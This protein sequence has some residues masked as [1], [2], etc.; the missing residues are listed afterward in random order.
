MSHQITILP[1]GKTFLA[2]DDET[3][4]D[5]ALRQGVGLPYGCRDGACGACKGSVLEGQVE[6]GP[7]KPHALSAAERAAGKALFCCASARSDLAIECRQV[8]DAAE[9]PART[10]PTRVQKLTR[11]ADDVAIIELKLPDKE[12]LP[13]R[14]GQYVDI[15]LRDGRR[16]SFSLANAPHDDLRLELHVRHIP[17]GAFTDHVFSTMKERDILR[18]NGPHGSFYLRQDSAKP[19]LLVAGGTGFAP[20]KA[21]VE[22]ARHAG[23]ERPMTL[24]WGARDRAGLYLHDLALGWSDLAY[25]PVLSAPA[26]DDHWRGRVGLVHEAVMADLPDLSGYQV[27]CCGAPAMVDAAR[28]DFTQRCALPEEAFFAD[29]FSYAVDSACTT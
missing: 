19:I 26:A 18:I 23:N 16:R 29:A 22:H 2:N 20:I 27:Y 3:L 24:Y 28:R 10:L 12:R 14:P 21:I 13:F 17:G 4:L 25:V 6:H 7:A 15:L 1:G 9:V 11:P 5:A 8:S